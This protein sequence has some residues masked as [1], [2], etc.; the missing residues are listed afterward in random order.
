MALNVTTSSP[1]PVDTL[2]VDVLIV[3][4]GPV[5]CAYARKLIESN[6]GLD[7]CMVDAGGQQSK[8]PGEHLKNAFVFQRNID[9]FVNVIRGH[10]NTISVPVDKRPTLTLDPGA[11]Q[12]DNPLIRNGQNPD[13]DGRYNLPAAAASYNVG[14]MATHWT[15]ACPR[16]HPEIE[17]WNVIQNWDD[18]Y[19]EAEILLNV[20][21]RKN[22]APHPFEQSVR[23][24]IVLGVLRQHFNNLTVPFHP[25]NL[26]L[27]CE[28]RSDNPEFV[29]WSGADTVL[30]PVLDRPD[31]Y[32]GK[33]TILEQHRCRQIITNSDN[34][35]VEAAVID[36]LMAWKTKIIKAKVYVICAGAVL[37]PQILY[38]SNIRPAPL[39]L[40]LSEQP[41]T[42]CQ[43]VMKQELL[44]NLATSPYLDSAAKKR[45][46]DYQKVHPEDPIPI[47]MT[48]PEPQVWI[49][50]S[51]Q[52]PW[53]AQ[54]H[55]DAFQ[56]GDIGPNVDSRVIVD[57]RWFGIVDQAPT[58]KV[59]FSGVYKDAF[60]MPQPTFHYEYTCLNT[61]LSKSRKSA[62]S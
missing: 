14:G 59:T 5:G 52:H 1:Q 33:L 36:D 21:P 55:R 24:Q 56:Y 16:H 27:A 7:V 11:F 37:T 6:R 18:L 38:N 43:I 49:P 4:S 29:R 23:H 58:N 44:D 10:L 26:P 60:G 61:T 28:R 42:F 30:G 39:G 32:K 53:H 47:P 35:S 15:C 51:K 3:G 48:E 20:H 41:M 50:V 62:I 13:Q 9:Q 19:D 2:T 57:L 46:T 54:I 12:P 31:N 40:Y 22:H 45:V 17:R 34:S 25:Q 8:R